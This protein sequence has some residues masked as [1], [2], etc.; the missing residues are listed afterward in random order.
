MMRGQLLEFGNMMEEIVKV[1][2]AVL[3]RK[4]VEAETGDSKFLIE[5]KAELLNLKDTDLQASSLEAIKENMK[6]FREFIDK[7][8]SANFSLPIEKA[9]QFYPDADIDEVKNIRK[10]KDLLSKQS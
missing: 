10:L 8:D 1:R 9:Y 6:K 5:I 7:V 2:K 4:L 3:E